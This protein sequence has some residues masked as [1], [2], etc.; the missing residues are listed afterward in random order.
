MQHEYLPIYVTPGTDTNNGDGEFTR[1]ALCK[2]GRD[3]FQNDGKAAELLEQMGIGYQLLGFSF[4]PGTDIVGAEFVDRLRGETE[5]PHY[6]DP[7]RE[8]ALYGFANLATAF[9]FDGIRMGDLHH[10]D[11]GV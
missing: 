7:C 9:Y 10:F 2:G 1:Y 11:G 4:F 5:V 3:F 8:Y 6:G